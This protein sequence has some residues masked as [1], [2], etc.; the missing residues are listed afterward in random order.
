MA[1]IFALL[2][3]VYVAV[4]SAQSATPTNWNNVTGTSD[5]VFPTDVGFLGK[6]AYGKTPFLAQKDKVNSSKPFG[7][8]GVET[9]VLPLNHEKD[10]ANS[11]DIFR[12]LGT[13]SVYHPAD[14]LF[15][16][17]HG[18]EV[19]P[20]QCNIKQV[21]ILHRH[22]ARNPTSDAHE[23]APM[24]G[25]AV[26]N[27]TKAGKLKATGDLS[28]L[29]HWNYTLGAEIL[30]H[31]GAQELFDSGVK[32]YYEYAAL[33]ENLT[34]HKPVIRTTSQ[35]RML[36]SARYWALGFFGWDA[37]QKTNLEVLTEVSDQNNTLAP[38]DYCTNSGN[39]S[40][41]LGDKLSSEWQKVYL[42]D[43]IQRL[44]KDLKGVKLDEKLLYG[45][46]SICA[47]ETVVMGYSDFCKLF[48]KEE[49]EHYEYDIDLQFMG[50]YGFMNP[51]GR[52]Q[53]IGY[54][55]EL[56]DRMN[57]T[58][59]DGPVTGQ[60]TTLDKNS[61]YFPVDQKLYAD[62]THDDVITS[63][64]TALNYT[65]IADFLPTTKPD[66]NRRYRSSRVTPFA[67][68]LVFEVLDCDSDDLKG[69]YLRTK[70]NE[71]VVPMDQDQGCEK[72]H[73]G[74]CKFDDFFSHQKK[75]AYKDSKYNKV[76][77]G[78]NGT[79]FTVTGPVRNGTI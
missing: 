44:Q 5:K 76:C 56:L 10:N 54:V 75:H 48:T 68:R 51:T 12:N 45:M 24:F 4:A 71:A 70:I 53:G 69:K 3:F 19:L 72:R 7:Y 34:D 28:F 65:Q 58:K 25:A 15:P 59:F 41:A 20:D 43:A 67:A 2:P 64:L 6:M 33:L 42:K 38:Y 37:P 52:A 47:Y 21:H 22:G 73:D 17:T 1:A 50:N 79:D 62:F 16:E 46:M 77:F 30:V 27:A 55:V 14:D 8:Y 11:D 66:S 35:S 49:F 78:K 32:H 13:T 9:R 60:N 39:S 74:L 36:D 31:Q 26:W 18:Y 29:N 23:G 40:Y 63:V 57:K 61:T